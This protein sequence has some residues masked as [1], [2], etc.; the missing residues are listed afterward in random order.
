MFSLWR[1]FIASYLVGILDMTLLIRFAQV[2]ITLPNFSSNSAIGQ[3]FPCQ[4][5]CQPIEL[6]PASNLILL[7][8]LKF[9][10]VN[11]ME[12]LHFHQF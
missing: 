3:H 11:S 5:H 9:S 4:T 7:V 8:S 12:K 2:A 10:K 1:T 6:G